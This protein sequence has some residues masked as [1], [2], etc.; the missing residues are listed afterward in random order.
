MV[1]ENE[2]TEINTEGH[3]LVGFEWP[4][5]GSKGNEYTVVML[6]RGFECNCPAYVKCKH[7]KGVEKGLIGD[8]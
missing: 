4:V 7:I 3:H 8:W 6:D 2:M 5:V 1:S